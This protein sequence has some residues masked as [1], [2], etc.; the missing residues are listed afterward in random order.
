[1][2]LNEVF[3]SRVVQPFGAPWIV[4]LIRV[5]TTLVAFAGLGQGSGPLWVGW[6][7]LSLS[8]CGEV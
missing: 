8:C 3:G 1:M 7:C 2:K 5:L 6:R 4:E